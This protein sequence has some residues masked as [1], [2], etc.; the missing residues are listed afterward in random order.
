[1]K[2][3]KE[4]IKQF[5]EDYG[6][7]KSGLKNQWKHIQ[8]CQAFYSGDYMNY[9][10][11]YQF[12]R[13]ASRRIKEV[14]FNSVK[15]YV[16]SI[17]GFMAQQR[18]KPDYQAVL[19]DSEEQRAFSDYLNGYSNYIR[20]NTNADQHETRQDMD[21][22]IGGVGVTDTAVTLKAGTPT[23]DPNGE[24]V[25]ER[26]NPL[27]VGWDPLAIHPNLLD[28]RF[29]YRAKDYDVDEALDL[30]DADEEDF[31]VQE[32]EPENYEFNPYGGITDKIGFEWADSSRK[33]V[34][35]YFYQWF[36]IEKFYRI[37]NPLLRQTNIELAQ[38]LANGLMAVKNEEEDE[39]FAFAPS[40]EVLVITKD[41]R[42]QVKEIFEMFE[43][44]FNPV[45]EKRMVFYT[46]VLS[47]D[48]VFSAYKSVS[49]QGFSLKFKTGDRDEK[50]KIWTG[51]VAS[52]RDPQRYY[53]KALTEIMLIIANNSRGGVLYEEDAV[54]NVQEF[55]ARWAMSNAAVKVNSGALSGGKI[56]D[57]ARPHMQNGY[58]GILT[59]SGVALSK[60]TGIDESF[61]GA[62]AGG[63][64]TAMLQRQRIKQAT[65]TLALYFDSI[66]LYA[67]EQGRMMLSFMRLLAE[68][69]RGKMFKMEDADG[70]PV[71]EMVS[72]DFFAD[73]YEIEIGESPETPVQKEYYTQT[74][75]GMAQSMQA[76]GDP[77]YTQMYA[78]AVKYMP[79]PNRDKNAIIEVLI[80]QQQ[81]DPAVVEQLQA[82]IQQ[83]QG[84]AAQL[85]AAKMTADIQKTQAE[86]RKTLEEVKEVVEKTEAAAVENDL[87]AMKS[88]QEVNVT[89]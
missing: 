63:N 1:M 34:R 56:Q 89:I 4:I 67:K 85:Q 84:Q 14:Q 87:M 5:K 20:V 69:S 78:A 43:I 71:F 22:V 51:I 19:P 53:N 28:S 8:E 32:D 62:I 55:E 12:G 24:V 65:T 57:K 39:M 54:D 49:Q 33:M 16:N 83:L 79:I 45:A 46:A 38:A 27:H 11:Q 21:M 13:G 68:S 25:V 88:P 74:L 50:N 86:T 81:V 58:E 40:A 37:E 29:V 36:E 59:E 48:K 82:Q 7:A 10:D 76:I 73:E 70:N 15:P 42:R 3:K 80:G 6:V 44:P 64:E 23:R 41:K 18:R 47:G 30:F 66:A 31:E 75:I 52:M 9:I 61:F 2:S 77:R 35:V 26:V 60:V 72:T 17:V